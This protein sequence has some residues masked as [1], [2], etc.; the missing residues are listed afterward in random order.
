MSSARLPWEVTAVMLADTSEGYKKQ[1]E[2]LI[3]KLCRCFDLRIKHTGLVNWVERQ[4]PRKYVLFT[5]N[6]SL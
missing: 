5:F 1:E 2:R 6:Y 3:S 4:H